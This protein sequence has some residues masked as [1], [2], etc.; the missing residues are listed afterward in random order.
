[1]CKAGLMQPTQSSFASLGFSS[2]SS[3]FH[4]LPPSCLRVLDGFS[5]LKV[6]RFPIP[7]PCGSPFLAPSKMSVIEKLTGRKAALTVAITEISRLGQSTT[8]MV[9]PLLTHSQTQY[10]SSSSSNQSHQYKHPFL[11]FLLRIIIIP[12]RGICGLATKTI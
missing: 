12:I 3:T 6:V 1:M 4:I 7:H 8:L 10:L 9:A 2:V 11:R 5:R